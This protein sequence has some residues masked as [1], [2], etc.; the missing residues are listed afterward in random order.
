MWDKCSGGDDRVVRCRDF[1]MVGG[2]V[3]NVHCKVMVEIPFDLK[4]ID[5]QQLV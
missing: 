3:I 4:M 1:G 2:W 5:D